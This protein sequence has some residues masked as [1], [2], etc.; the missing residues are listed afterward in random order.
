LRGRPGEAEAARLVAAPT[1]LVS[2]L[3]LVTA[4]VGEDVFK[5]G[6]FADDFHFLDI[7]RRFP[8]H[9]TLWGQWGI[10]PWFRPLSRELYYSLAA[11]AGPHA[12][13]A[14]HAMSLLCLA[15]C[16][17]CLWRIGARLIGALPAA[18]ATALFVSYDFTKFLAAW[19]SGFQD[20]L[21][22][23]LILLSVD[24]YMNRRYTT[25]LT[26]AL[27]APFAK[28]TGAIIFPLLALLMVLFES[29][30]SRRWT[31]CLAAGFVAVIAVHVAVRLAWHGPGGVLP[32]EHP[33]RELATAFTQLIVALVMWPPQPGTWSALVAVIA[34]GSTLM[35]V[36]A[37][38]RVSARE[39]TP[40]ALF[41]HAHLWFLLCAA[42]LGLLPMIVSDASGL[43]RAP[44]YYAFPALPWI[45]LILS[46][47]GTRLTGRGWVPIAALVVGWN[48][49]SLGMHRPDL[50]GPDGWHFRRWDW[51][52]AVRLSEVSARLA[53]DVRIECPAGRESLVVLY[54]ELPGGCWFQTEDGPATRVA[55]DDPTARGFWINEPAPGVDASRLTILTFDEERWHLRRTSWSASTALTRAMKALIAMHGPAASAFAGYYGDPDSASFDRGYILAAVALLESG[56]AEYVAALRAAGLTDTLG[57]LPD[58]LAAPLA[59]IDSEVASAFANAL[60]HPRSADSHSRL[61]HALAERRVLTRAGFELRIALL[62]DPSR[63]RDRYDLA[64]TM[65]QL[66]GVSEARVELLRLAA[67]ST[68]GSYGRAAARVVSEL[69]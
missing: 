13:L 47:L 44:P 8:L 5:L 42:A 68:A 69:R 40:R 16:A 51:P 25:A 66:G 30:P 50:S 21:A 9:R 31:Y 60:R 22:L 29:R 55:L 67:D 63:H 39:W 43:T 54:E 57:S 3:L 35:L 59:T 26:C 28:E 20:C 34:V 4:A 23:L 62:L 36:A 27:L 64:R 41:K 33:A 18:T 24:G 7:A 17:Y 46:G 32:P 11:A 49:F 6:F 48:T 10:W 65:L 1:I 61:G 58:D 45:F 52:E 38:K 19:P 14:A 2:I 12:I 37:S 53:S 56:P 15:A